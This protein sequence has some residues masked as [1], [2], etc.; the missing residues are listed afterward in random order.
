MFFGSLNYLT[1]LCRSLPLQLTMAA[2]LTDFFKCLRLLP[3]PFGDYREN[4]PGTPPF[5]VNFRSPSTL[6][7]LPIVL[8]DNEYLYIDRET[9]CKLSKVCA[10]RIEDLEKEGQELMIRLDNITCDI[11]ERVLFAA[12]PAVYGQYPIPPTVFDVDVICPVACDLQMN[13]VVKMCEQVL[14][15]DV[16]P[17]LTATDLL[18]SLF[19]VAYKCQLKPVLQAKLLMKIMECEY[20][21]IRYSFISIIE[22][23]CLR[24]FL[25]NFKEAIRHSVNSKK[26]RKRN[27]STRHAKFWLSQGSSLQETE[28]LQLCTYHETQFSHLT[29]TVSTRIYRS[30]CKQCEEDVTRIARTGGYRLKTIPQKFFLCQQCGESLCPK[31]ETR[32][33]VAKLIEFLDN[34]RRAD[35]FPNVMEK[36]QTLMWNTSTQDTHAEES[37]N[38]SLFFC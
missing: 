34:V 35:Q 37:I 11:M 23:P 19:N 33:C 14:E 27:S 13:V 31:C 18:I 12:C 10:A 2:K 9:I 3:V 28:L 21:K 22:S 38:A 36:L 7:K 24:I 29:T 5:M 4:N 20:W 8:K 15:N 17:E 25:W 16:H 32:C 1:N 30:S 6:R 26:A